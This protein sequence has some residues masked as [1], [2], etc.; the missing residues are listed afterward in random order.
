MWLDRQKPI[1]V[2]YHPAKFGGHRHSGSGEVIFLVCHVILTKLRHKQLLEQ[3]HLGQI[4]KMYLL[5][6]FGDHLSYRNEDMNF[7]SYINSYMDTLEKAKLTDSI[8]HIVI[9]S[10]SVILIQNCEVVETA[11][12]KTRS[13]WRLRHLGSKPTN[14]IR[15]ITW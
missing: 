2:R 9:F 8:H 13:C 11:G 7:N 15:E 10:K 1:K 4:L 5:S 14:D 12:R 3:S 6:K